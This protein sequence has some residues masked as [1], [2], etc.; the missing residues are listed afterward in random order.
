ML[1]LELED[2]DNPFNHAVAMGATVEMPVAEM[3][4]AGGTASSAT[5]SGITGHCAHDGITYHPMRSPIACR[6]SG[7]TGPGPVASGSLQ[8]SRFGLS[9]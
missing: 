1:L 4:W 3:F 5:H 6:L 2:V 9:S 7:P 8:A